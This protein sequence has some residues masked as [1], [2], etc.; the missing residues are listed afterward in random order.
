MMSEIQETL[1][2]LIKDERE[3]QDEKWGAG[4]KLPNEVWLTILTEEVGE[5]AQATLKRDETS[6]IMELLQ[7]ASVSLAWLEALSEVGSVEWETKD[8]YG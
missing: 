2:R 6:L 4:R 5:A 1:I 3:R 8:H 7:V